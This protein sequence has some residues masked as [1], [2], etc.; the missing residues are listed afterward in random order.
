MIRCSAL[1]SALSLALAL[2]LASTSAPA[3]ADMGCIPNENFGHVDVSGEVFG[4]N[5]FVMEDEFRRLALRRTEA[6]WRIEVLRT[7][8]SIAPVRT[9]PQGT[10]NPYGV[11][12][13]AQD[14]VGPDR[15]ISTQR[16]QYRHFIFGRDAVDPALNP[17][18][19]VPAPPPGAPVNVITVEPSEGEMG[20]GEVVIE[21]IGVT[22]IGLSD[23]DLGR[24]PRLTYLKFSACLGW[25][26]GYQPPGW[27]D[28]AD[29]GV[30]DEVVKTMNRCG[31]DTRQ[32]RLSDYT[33]KWSE[34]GSRAFLSPDLNGDTVNE[35]IAPVRDNETGAKGLAICIGGDNRIQWVGYDELS[36]EIGDFIPHADYWVANLAPR[37]PGGFFPRPAGESFSLGITRGPNL[38][39]YM[40]SEETLHTNRQAGR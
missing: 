25:N 13:N 12:I 21:D 22:D 39:I 34:S 29:P 38:M 32:Y 40:D 14:F 2:T 7:D 6:G 1:F 10:P 20:I 9:R 23:M 5:E 3:F 24:T 26:R 4:D 33:T 28:H 8:G 17:E 30:P 16:S 19:R 18:L 37:K 11:H 27:R 15:A 36:R 35:M 31:F